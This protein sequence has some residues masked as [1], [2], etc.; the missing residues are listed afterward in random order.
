MY[1]T[2]GRPLVAARYRDPGAAA[3][4]RSLAKE[5][6]EDT[7]LNEIQKILY[8]TEVRSLLLLPTALIADN[9]PQD[10]FEVPEGGVAPGDEE[11]TF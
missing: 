9:T 5:G 3:D 7:T 6:S 11:E 2:H 1:F 8:S 4:G 10:G